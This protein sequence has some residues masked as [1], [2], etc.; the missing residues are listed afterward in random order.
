M[1]YVRDHNGRSVEVELLDRVVGPEREES[2]AR[3][4]YCEASDVF[5]SRYGIMSDMFCPNIP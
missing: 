4:K 3:P 2:C 1:L 5:K